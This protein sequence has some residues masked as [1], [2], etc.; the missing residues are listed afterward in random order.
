MKNQIKTWKAKIL[1]DLTCLYKVDMKYMEG[2]S[3]AKIAILRI[4][5]ELYGNLPGNRLKSARKQAGNLYTKESER[6]Y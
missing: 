2:K 3:R 5:S 6:I 1:S 4:L